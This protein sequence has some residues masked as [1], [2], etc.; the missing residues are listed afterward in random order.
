MLFMI[1]CVD[2]PDHGRVRADNRP[3]HLEH[4]KAQGER[5]V[6]AGPTLDDDGNPD[7]SVLIVEFPDRAAA[8]TFAAEDPYSKAGL[9]QRVEIKPWKKAFP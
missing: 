7:G 4:L 5:I 8:E 9:F 6:T 3:A 1:H 2:K